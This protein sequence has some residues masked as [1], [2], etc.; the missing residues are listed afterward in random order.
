MTIPTLNIIT[1]LPRSGTSLVTSILAQNPQIHSECDSFLQPLLFTMQQNWPRISN[2]KH[3]KMPDVMRGLI[4]GYYRDCRSSVIFDRNLMWVPFLPMLE[5]ILERQV[6]VLVCVRNPAEILTSFERSRAQ[7][8][9]SMTAADFKLGNTSNLA[10]RCFFYSGPDGLLGT[11]H[12]NLRDSIIMGLL[13]R[14]LF[15]DYGL[16]CGNPRSQT[17]RIYD[18]FELD[19]FEH[20]FQNI[21][22]GNA[23]VRPR[24]EKVSVNCV[25]YL[26]LDLFEQYNS[27]VFWNAWV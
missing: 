19:P 26:G 11:T 7:D 24:L 21:I 6:R 18:F 13:D 14:M 17:K 9:L 2:D 23:G 25:Q 5:Q 27:Q 4:Q 22:P 8:P 10:A 20:D 1:G 16:Y 12:M 3:T 15:V